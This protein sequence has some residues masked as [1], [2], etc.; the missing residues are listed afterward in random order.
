MVEE[1]FDPAAAGRFCPNEVSLPPHTQIKPEDAMDT[2]EVENVKI[3]G[4]PYTKTK[5]KDEYRDYDIRGES[6]LF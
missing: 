4:T 3:C 1:W 5:L 6:Q 2:D